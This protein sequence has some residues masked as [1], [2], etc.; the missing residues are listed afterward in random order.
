MN[1]A[2]HNRRQSDDPAKLRELARVAAE[3]G[4][5]QHPTPPAPVRPAELAGRGLLVKFP[6]E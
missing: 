1:T 4:R 5:T 6:W 2:N 3:W